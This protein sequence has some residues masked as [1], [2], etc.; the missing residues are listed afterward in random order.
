MSVDLRQNA[1]INGTT[2]MNRTWLRN[3]IE[4]DYWVSGRGVSCT[5]N[6][7]GI[8]ESAVMTAK[9]AVVFVTENVTKHAA[10]SSK[11][12]AQNAAFLATKNAT[13]DAADHTPNN[14]AAVLSTEDATE[15]T[16]AFTAEHATYNST[17][18]SAE[19]TTKNT[20]IIIATAEMKKA[21][22]TSEQ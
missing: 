11:G 9:K 4:I 19:N 16:T 8:N 7:T 18:F 1:D 13:G 21:S 10:Y 5:K 17:T 12:A 15:K 20:A 3:E 2:L 22:E 6:R 14:T